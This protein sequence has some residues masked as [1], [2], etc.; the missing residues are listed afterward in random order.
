MKKSLTKALMGAIASGMATLFITAATWS[1][2]HGDASGHD[3]ERMMT[4]MAKMLDLTEE[5]QARVETLLTTAFEEAGV[6]AER[7]HILSDEILGQPETFDETTAQA[8]A[9]EIG[10]I[11]SHMIYRMASTHAAI[12]QLLDDEQQLAMNDLDEWSGA[13]G[14]KWRGRQRY[15]F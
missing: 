6:D 2:P 11:A 7:L 10:R 13:R 4:Y 3:P 5:Q 12:Y 8:T 9:D 14:E 1:M 15:P